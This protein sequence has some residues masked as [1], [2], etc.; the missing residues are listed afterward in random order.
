[1][2]EFAFFSLS[3]E[4][5]AFSDLREDPA[6]RRIPREKRRYYLEEPIRLGRQAAASYQGR[7]LEQILRDEGVLIQMLHDEPP[8][9]LHAQILYDGNRREIQVF[10]AVARHLS[11]VMAETPFAYT[12]EQ[13]EKL[14]LAHEFYH[15][16]EYSSQTFTDALCEPVEGK[17]LGLFRSRMRVRRTCEIAAFQFAKEV[18]GLTIHPKIMDYVLLYRDKGEAFAEIDRKLSALRAAYEEA[19][20]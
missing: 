10:T 20:L 13:L 19:C 6:Y 16:L 9:Y 18:C 14:F 15:W 7:D 8:G 17:L 11:E 5:F 12:P 4:V 3:D 1:M 2:N